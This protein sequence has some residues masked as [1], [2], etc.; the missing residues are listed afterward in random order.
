MEESISGDAVLE[1]VLGV[2]C[3]GISSVGKVMSEEVR[4]D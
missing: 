4:L 3:E 1:T 2:V